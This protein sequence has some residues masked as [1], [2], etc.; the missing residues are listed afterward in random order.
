MGSRAQQLFVGLSLLLVLGAGATMCHATDAA[1]GLVP[2][3]RSLRSGTGEFVAAERLVIYLEGDRSQLARPA[4][5]LAAGLSVGADAVPTQPLPGEIPAGALLLRLAPDRELGAEG[6]ALTVRPEQVILSAPAEAGLQRGAQTLLQLLPVGGTT[7]KNLRLP[8]LEIRDWPRFPYR[9]MHLDVCRHFFPVTFIKRYLD[10]LALHKFNRFHWHLTEDQ[11]WRIEIR[12]YPELARVASRRAET[13]VG[14]YSDQPHQFDGRPH[15]GYFTQEEVREVVAYA[16]ALGITVIPEIEM[17]GHSL[18]ALAAYP[19]LSC[20]GGPFAPATKWGVFPDVYCAG[21]DEVFRFLEGVLDEVIAL[22]P[23]EYIHIGGDECPKTR[24]EECPKCQARMEAEGLDSEHEL[25]SWFIRRIENFL[26]SQGR[27]LIGWDEILEGGL[28]PDATVMS[29]RGVAGGIEAAQQGHDVIMT[30][31]THCYFDHYQAGPVGEPLAIGGMTT[32]RKVYGFEP[33]PGELTE[34]QAKHVLGA[35]GNVWTEYI[36]TPEQVEYMIL[37]RMCALAEVLWTPRSQREWAGFQDRLG[38]HLRRLSALG[39]NYSRGSFRVSVTSR[40]DTEYGRQE[41]LLESEQAAPSIVYTLDGSMPGTDSPRFATPIPCADS[42]TLKTGLTGKGLSATGPQDVESMGPVTI[43]EYHHH[44]GVGSHIELG[45]AY[46][47]R[48]AGGGERALVDGLTG[49]DHYN[50]GRWQGYE[51]VDLELRFDLGEPRALRRVALHCLVDTGAWIFP[52]RGITLELA[53][54]D[55]AF[56][57]AACTE[58]T[59][60]ED[61]QPREARRYSFDLAGQ[62][63]RYLRLQVANTGVC[64]AWHRGAGNPCWVF[65]DEVIVE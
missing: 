25:Q 16:A 58:H 15:G 54:E 11:G 52:P 1:A 6:Y 55:G 40:Y 47:T 36:A 50:D 43:V 33:V 65:V 31:G 5:L 8:C 51:G 57:E 38:T 42:F 56:H 18:A 12:R 32:L 44:L 9:G 34:T 24:W 21:N 27:R 10:L 23:G 2:L 29:W 28:A 59:V 62:S 7:D 3:P 39:A 22:F 37:P 53:G 63:A 35:Q 41:L 14:H 30:P 45:T 13:L 26:H 20:T 64:P 49:S 46:A 17:P 48:Y 60:C 61:H 4:A 19:E